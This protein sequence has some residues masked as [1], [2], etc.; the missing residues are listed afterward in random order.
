M[1]M[2]ALW[3]IVCT[4]LGIRYHNREAVVISA[5]QVQKHPL[6]TPGPYGTFTPP[7]MRHFIPTATALMALQSTKSSIGVTSASSSVGVTSTTTTTTT[8]SQDKSGSHK[9]TT[10]TGNGTSVGASV[11]VVTSSK[12]DHPLHHPVHERAK[13]THAF[14]EKNRQSPMTGRQGSLERSTGSPFRGRGSVDRSAGSPRLRQGSVER[15]IGSPFFG[16]DSPLMS[17]RASSPHTFLDGSPRPTTRSISEFTRSLM[18]SPRM[19]YRHSP[20]PTPHSPKIKLRYLVHAT[21]SH[22]HLCSSSVA[23][24]VM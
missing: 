8:A 23:Y 10:T 9:V 12:I 21:I 15:S 14:E 13:G 17:S 18:D 3:L 11:P 7:P 6:A 24:F 4:N 2:A 20:R 19:D 1:C 16:R 22:Y 5:L